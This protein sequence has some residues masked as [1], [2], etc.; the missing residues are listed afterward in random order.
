MI[1]LGSDHAGFTLKEELKRYLSSKGEDIDDVGTYSSDPVDYP[2]FAAEVAH[3]VALSRGKDRGILVCG[4]GVGMAIAANKIDGIRAV[5]ADSEEIAKKS[6]E[7]DD[8]NVLTLA[9]RL[10]ETDRALSITDVWLKTPFSNKDRH[11]RRIQEI[12]DLEDS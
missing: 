5:D 12:K 8:T 9:G 11:V 2:E 7:D 3:K 4:S 10:L 6:R 1:I